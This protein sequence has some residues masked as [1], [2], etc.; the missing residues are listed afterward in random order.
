MR[1]EV[2]TEFPVGPE[3][4]AEWDALVARAALSEPFVTRGWMQAAA[5]FDREAQPLIICG[6]V[7][8]D[9]GERL[10]AIAPFAQRR[11]R[12]F[13]RSR[14]ALEMLGS[15]WGDYNDVIAEPGYHAEFISRVAEQIAA[16]IPDDCVHACLEN[17]PED[18]PTL[19][20]L[21]DR[22]CAQGLTVE[23]QQC[24]VGMAL[25]IA[26]TDP[27]ALDGLL[28]KERL[29]RK[30]KTLARTARL[31]FRVVRAA[32]EMRDCLRRLSRWHTARYLLNG[33]PS[34]FD[35][36]AP[37]NLCRLLDLT[38]AAM[39]GEACLP[40]LFL[41]DEP[42]A[43]T[44]A[45]EHRGA[46]L[47]WVTSF[48]VGIMGTSPGEMLVLET[49]RYCRREGLR[50]LDFGRG[51]ESYKSRFTNSERR[52][53]RLIIHRGSAA[54]TVSSALARARAWAKRQPELWDAAVR[55]RGLWQLLRLEAQRTG[56][57]RAAIDLLAEQGR[58]L[59]FGNTVPD[60]GDQTEALPELHPRRLVEVVLKYRRDLPSWEFRKA[61]ELLRQGQQC[62]LVI[63]DD[64]LR[65]IVPNRPA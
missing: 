54:V 36:E 15:C 60:S 1:I 50:K 61:Y 8:E 25:Q 32:A 21:M 45:F 11:I 48:D 43:V 39:P 9:G 37:G 40:A 18:S 30:M 28:K 57:S 26:G 24:D 7:A 22:A 17:I 3:R 51:S 29:V 38:V 65:Q 5:E 16:I 56:L 62:R 2:L 63:E 49:A 35:A 55:L 27:A 52:I 47:T 13:G 10:V 14:T 23:L 64:R 6:Y 53:Y 20:A 34:I 59:L 42:V 58:A 41:D 31:E 44:L 19:G 4:A 46:L 12:S 33:Q